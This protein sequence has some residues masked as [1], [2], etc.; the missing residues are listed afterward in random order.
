MRKTLDLAQWMKLTKEK[1]WQKQL[2]MERKVIPFK[3]KKSWISL[4]FILTTNYPNIST[5]IIN[6]VDLQIYT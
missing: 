5:L 4:K 1:V 3:K 2:Q 6:K